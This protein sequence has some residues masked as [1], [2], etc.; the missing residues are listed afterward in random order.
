M[1]GAPKKSRGL[2]FITGFITGGLTGAA[3]AVIYERRAQ[4]P[5]VEAARERG[6]AMLREVGALAGRAAGSIEDLSERTRPLIE[7][8]QQACAE[9]VQDGRARVA[10][11]VAGLQRRQQEPRSEAA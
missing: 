5:S 9:A 2:G 11:T 7:K 6:S 3:A 1:A 10:R 8:T 4:I